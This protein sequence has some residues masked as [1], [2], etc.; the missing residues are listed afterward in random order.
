MNMFE[1]TKT[2]LFLGSKLISFNEKCAFFAINN[3]CNSRCEMCS[4]WKI[5]DKK[6]VKFKEAKK[7]LDILHKNKFGVVQITGGEPFLNPDIFKII[8]YAKK[9]GFIVFIPTNG[10]LITKDFADKLAESKVDQISISLHHNNPKIFE[11][12]EGHKNILNKALQS[13]ENLKEKGVP[14][15]ALCT[16]SKY[17]VNDIEDVVK[18]VEK[19]GIA[20]SF[21]TPITKTETSYS[22]GGDCTNLKKNEL[23]K[24]I[25]KI[26]KLKKEGHNITNNMSYLNDTLSSLNGKSKY[27]CY[28]GSKLFYLDWNLDIYPCMFKGEGINIKQA[29]FNDPEQL[30][31]ECLIQ[32]F[33]EPSLLLRSRIE[34][35]KLLLK[36]SHIM[37]TCS[38]KKLKF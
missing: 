29:S 21:S 11:R 19:I 1:M 24:V 23:K 10:T 36:D 38:R 28:G 12:I 27:K 5:K 31:D 13:I 17:N 35:I 2:L 9:I 8:K 3:T 30:C 37:L 32:C 14:V 18:F 16:I 26:I 4:I 6:V 22:L 15:S 34:A 33:R 25:S 20:I 7:A